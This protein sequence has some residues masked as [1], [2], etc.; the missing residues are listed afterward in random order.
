MIELKNIEKFYEAGGSRSYV[1]RRINLET[2]ELGFVG[3]PDDQTEKLEV[4]P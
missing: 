4:G 1:L 3:F 2:V